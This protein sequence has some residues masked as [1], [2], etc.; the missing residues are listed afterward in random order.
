VDAGVGRASSSGLRESGGSSLLQSLLRK[1]GLLRREI[2]KFP[3]RSVNSGAQWF[4]ESH[5]H[6][7]HKFAGFDLSIVT[8]N[9]TTIFLSCRTSLRK[10]SSHL[11]KG[12]RYS[13]LI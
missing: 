11:P 10:R 13:H 4:S 2:L 12:L 7:C 9:D 8:S 3:T 1:S 5:F 6:S